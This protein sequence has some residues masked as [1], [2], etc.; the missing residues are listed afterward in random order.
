MML[1]PARLGE[2]F[3]GVAFLSAAAA[4]LL[5]AVAAR[6]ARTSAYRGARS[7]TWLAMAALLAAVAVLGQA[8][9]RGDYR[10][11]EVF[12]HADHL[13]P[14]PYRWAALYAGQAG[15]LLLWAF[16]LAL[17]LVFAS[18]PRAG[19]EA[20]AHAWALSIGNGLLFFFVALLLYAE[21]PFAAHP[22]LPADGLGLNPILQ[23]PAMLFHPPLLYLGE[24][25]F[26]IPLIYAAGEG[27]AGED[28]LFARQR[29]HWILLA[30]GLLGLGNL[31]GAWWAYVELGWGGYWGWD[32]VENASLMPWLAGAALLHSQL[33]PPPTGG[34]GMTD[35]LLLLGTFILTLVGT[36]I[37]R[38]GMIDSVHTFSR[39]AV[40]APFLLL[41]AAAAAGGLWLTFSRRR[42]RP[43]PLPA[44][45]C[46][47][48]ALN[49][50][51][52]WAA[53]AVFLVGAG[54]FLP[55]LSALFWGRKLGV[56][57]GYYQQVMAP[58]GCLLLALLAIGLRLPWR[59]MKFAALGKAMAAPLFS[60]GIALLALWLSGLR[61]RYVLV[62]LALAAAAAYVIAAREMR[63]GREGIGAAGVF[64]YVR[65][66]AAAAGALLAHLGVL[67]LFIGFA[68]SFFKQEKEVNLRA[69]E[70]T[71]FAE[72]E[73]TLEELST[74]VQPEKSSVIAV[75]SVTSPQGA[76]FWARPR[77]DFFL[78][79]RAPVTEVAIRSRLFS[80]LYFILGP[81]EE[82]ESS[83]H[84][85][86]MRHPLVALIWW[87]GLLLSAG[88]F[89]ALGR[90]RPRE[91]AGAAGGRDA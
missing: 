41:I 68:G 22:G 89:L 61:Q 79:S 10:L 24:I 83:A 71:R 91:L 2:F 57:P 37:T 20:G 50:L 70:M 13:L 64:G 4:A 58:L 38:S 19:Q 65:R 42:R 3:L 47:Q 9:L 84:I 85:K 77:Q 46:R 63:L 6:R 43:A 69:G 53:V 28:G 5:A 59:G 87:G 86:M 40:G 26:A 54:V 11:E 62:S 81:F 31:S 21:R 14:W 90:P 18:R 82:S 17:C 27:L 45:L 60:G 49:L 35:R 36:W 51:F 80:D 8:F 25:A 16:L 56:G 73:V 66:R 55:L 44:L 7:C 75:L 88:V 29:R 74:R 33:R 1:G 67:L 48:G 72:Y 34:G 32:A 76:R 12:R 39:S 78:Q 15:S 52:A 30:F 23:H